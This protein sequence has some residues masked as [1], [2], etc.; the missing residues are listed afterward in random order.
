MD[1]SLGIIKGMANEPSESRGRDRAQRQ[2]VIQRSSCSSQPPN[3]GRA[4]GKFQENHQ[5]KELH[6]ANEK[7]V[8][9]VWVRAWRSSG[10]AGVSRASWAWRVQ[11]STR[12]HARDRM[13]RELGF[14]TQA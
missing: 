13:Q 9:T 5:N 2:R 8:L 10:R 11:A 1:A 6:Q 14:N 12:Q 4:R 3:G 7:Y